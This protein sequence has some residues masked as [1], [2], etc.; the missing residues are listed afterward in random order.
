MAAINHAFTEQNSNQTT[1]S[2]TFVDVTGA[3]ISS[4]SFTAGK[5][6]LLYITAQLGNATAGA[7]TGVQTVHGSTVF[8]ESA[9]GFLAIANNNRTVYVFMDVWTAVSGEGIKLQFA[10]VGGTASL[11][12]I[13]M[14]AINLSDD[15]T[16]G[17]DWH[18]NERTTDDTLSGTP[19]AGAAVTFT[20]GTAGHDW[21]VLTTAQFLDNAG[22][23]RCESEIVRSGEASSSLP[24]SIIGMSTATQTYISGLARVFNLGAA[25]NT[26]TEQSTGTSGSPT[27]LHSAVFALNLNKF[28]AHANAYT[29]ADTN[30]SATNYATNLQ[31]ASITPTVTGDVWIGVAWGFDKA[32]AARTAEFRLQVDD[33]DVPAG[34]TTD[35]YNMRISNTNAADEEPMILSTL[36]SLSNSAHT[37]DLDASVSSATSTPTG[38]QQSVWGV[39][40]ELVAAAPPVTLAFVGSMPVS[41]AGPLMPVGYH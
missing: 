8:A 2:D 13:S 27:R 17:T 31:T 18:Y 6:Y 33:A 24:Q 26:F 35:N 22:G 11:D 40:L 37:L 30:L 16:E 20:P 34:Q 25:S 14:L 32:N 23:D 12:H 9:S 36:T 29:E 3:S 10:D 1:T 38:Q 39:T 5:K 15:L 41:H 4:G 7:F 19:T 21:L 28:A